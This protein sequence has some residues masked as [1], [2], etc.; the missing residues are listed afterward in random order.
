M[1]SVPPSLDPRLVSRHRT[2]DRDPDLEVIVGAVGSAQELARA[3]G[4]LERRLDADLTRTPSARAVLMAE[5]APAIAARGAEA[6]DAAMAR[7]REAEAKL[8]RRIAAPEGATNFDAETR[9]RLAERS[10]SARRA[11]VEEALASGDEIV[12]GAILRAPAFLSGLSS[13]EVERA[14]DAWQRAARPAEAARLRG[15]IADAERA[16]AALLGVAAAYV[17]APGV[18][19]AADKRAA[20]DAALREGRA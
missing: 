14:R 16:G 7:V 18:A 9:A 15:A 4:D 6:I 5:H 17:S 19:E 8:A 10:L 11:L 1:K 20:A 3:I 13:A 2:A 12:L